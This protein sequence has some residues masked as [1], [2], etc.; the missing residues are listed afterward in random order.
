MSLL[1]KLAI[2]RGTDKSSEVHN[3]CVKYEKYLPFKRTD[4]LKI[5]EIGVLNGESLRMWKDYFMLS[6]IIGIDIDS[7]C[8][9]NEE[10]RI[11]VEIGSQADEKF[12]NEVGE[13]YEMFD[14]IL[15]DGSHINEHVIFSFEKLFKYV[16][17]GGVYIVEDA[18]TSYWEYYGGGYDKKDTTIEYFKKL[19]EHVNLMGL[20]KFD[21]LDN[22]HARREDLMIPYTLR[23]HPNCITD[24][25]SINFL[26]GIIIITKSNGT[27]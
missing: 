2:L 8:K 19:I 18:C 17:P 1:D 21:A 5:L 4:K 13:K 3:Y 22:A 26:N 15:D 12:L 7:R 20:V 9:E 23:H 14:M 27:R 10:E 11:K 6:E 24:I 25:E 16:K